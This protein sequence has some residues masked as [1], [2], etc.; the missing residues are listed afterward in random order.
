[1]V[2]LC[3]RTKK[4]IFVQN[5]KKKN[6]TTRH[7]LPLQIHSRCLNTSLF[8]ILP[9]DQTKNNKCYTRDYP[10]FGNSYALALC[11][12]LQGNIIVSAT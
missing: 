1:M 8:I 4:H 7:A 10:L 2:I 6:K 5:Y 3:F 9:C 12:H 11:H